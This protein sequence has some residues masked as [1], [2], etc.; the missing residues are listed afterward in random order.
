MSPKAA[1]TRR[2]KTLAKQGIGHVGLRVADIK[3]STEFYR[4]V[5]GLKAHSRGEGVARIPSGPDLIVLHRQEHR[6][7]RFHFGF[8]VDSP[9][10]VDNWRDWF[11]TKGLRIDQDITEEDYRSIKI[12]DPDGYLIEIACDK[13]RKNILR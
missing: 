13:R 6:K 3:K 2:P 9:T 10:T 12:R 5:L 1:T 4:D 11:K 7:S 8:Y